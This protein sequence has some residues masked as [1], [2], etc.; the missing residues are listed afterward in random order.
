MFLIWI[1]ISQGVR[2]LT[3]FWLKSTITHESQEM[4]FLSNMGDFFTVFSVL[5]GIFLITQAIFGLFSSLSNLFAAKNIFQKITQKIIY[6]KIDFFEKNS[7][8]RIVNR[9]SNDIYSIDQWLPY[10][11]RFFIEYFLICISAPIVIIIQLPYMAIGI[12]NNY[13]RYF[14]K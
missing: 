3:D 9:I 6:S 4:D 2:I 7:V 10:Y 14:F 12:E 11:L 1:S 8:G 5:I 13:I